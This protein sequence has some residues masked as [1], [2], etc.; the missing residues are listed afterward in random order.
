[1]SALTTILFD[2][3]DTLFD[4][5]ACWEK[6]MQQ[7][8]ATHPLTADLDGAALLEALR[9]HGDDLWVDVIAKRYDFTQYRQ[10]RLQRAMADFNRQISA[11]EVDGFQQAYAAACMNAVT[12]DS[13]VQQLI[14]ELAERYT[15]GIVTNGPVDMAF[16]KL[17]RLGLSDYFPKERVFLSELIGYHKPDPRI[18]ATVLQELGAE[19]AQVLFVGDTWDA[20]VAGAMDAGMS[21]VW[22]NPKG[23]KPATSHQPL[24]TIER[25]EQLR[26]Y[27]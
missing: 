11:E 18:Y 19:P 26:A 3:D 6:G 7:T 23:K 2:L 22:I 24:A 20:D 14:S 4:F 1:M 12:G 9:R 16:I 25:L 15:L 17:S 8:V 21:A 27:V 5:S 10:L 13:A